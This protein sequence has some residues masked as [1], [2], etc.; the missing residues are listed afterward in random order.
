FLALSAGPLLEA[1]GGDEERLGGLLGEGGA[2][3]HAARAGRLVEKGLEGGAGGADRVQAKVVEEGGILRGDE[4]LHQPLGNSL[5][6]D[7]LAAFLVE[8]SGQYL[9]VGE[10]LG[11]HRWGVG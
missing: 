10:D 5:V 11:E 7:H 8:F 3:L 9:V 4:G 2:S 6:G 1:L